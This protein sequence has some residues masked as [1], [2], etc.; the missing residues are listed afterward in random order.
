MTD[1]K[2]YYSILGL[3]KDASENDIKKAYRKMAAKYHP[4]K[5]ATKSEQEKKDAEEKFKEINEANSVLSDP[6][7]KRNYDQFGDPNGPSMNG[8]DPFEGMD[9]FGMGGFGFGRQKMVKKGEDLQVIVNITLE[10]VLNGGTKEVTFQRK[11]KCTHCNGTGNSSGKLDTCP[12]CG[13]SGRIRTKTQQGY[14]TMI[15]ETMCQHC[16]GSGKISNGPKCTHCNG[17][18]YELITKKIEVSIP[19]GVETGMAINYPQEG[20]ES[21]DGGINGDL[22]VVFGVFEH[23]KFKRKGNDL[24]IDLPLTLE[25]AWCGCEKEIVCL[26]GKSVRFK[27]SELTPDGKIFRLKDKGVPNIKR[28]YFNNEDNGSLYVKVVYIVPK[29]ISKKQKEILK[30]FYKN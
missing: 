6:E 14:M 27:I 16:M 2:D 9:P 21:F 11:T 13:G 26:D 10:E 24:Y 30:E 8:F 25:E 7:K 22:H 20:H 4:D 19:K 18:G 1:N 5:F 17:R 23:N 12:H 3:K 29:T 28:T 15:N